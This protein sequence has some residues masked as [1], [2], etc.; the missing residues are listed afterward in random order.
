MRGKR[1]LEKIVARDALTA[2]VVIDRALVEEVTVLRADDFVVEPF[3][4][5]QKRGIRLEHRIDA[6][7]AERVVQTVFDE[8]VDDRLGKKVQFSGFEDPVDDFALG[9]ERLHAE[10]ANDVLLRRAEPLGMF[11][12]NDANE[13][14][15]E[16]AVN[17]LFLGRGLHDVGNALEPVAVL[18]E[19]HDDEELRE[20]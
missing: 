7:A 13:V 17:L 15:A 4:L 2:F 5:F 3:G 16:V 19:R 8:F 18:V 9:A 11:F 1:G 10:C 12:L 6:D 14:D 20:Q